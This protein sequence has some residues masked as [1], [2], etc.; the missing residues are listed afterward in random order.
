[1][2]INK[3]FILGSLLAVLLAAAGLFATHYFQSGRIGQAMLF[4]ADQ[5]RAAGTPD[6]EAK[7]L[8][9]YLEFRPD[10]AANLAR[11]AKLQDR[12][13]ISGKGLTAALFLYEKLLRLEP[14]DLDAR[15]AAA[16]LCLRLGRSADAVEHLQPLLKADPKDTKLHERLGRCMAAAGKPEE[17][18]KALQKAVELDPANVPA[19]QALIALALEERDNPER[20]KNARALADEMVARNPRSADA[21]LTMARLKRSQ[22][23][24]ADV[25][26]EVEAAQQ[27]DPENAEALVFA[28][29]AAQRAGKAD[30]A[31]ACYAA[32]CD[33]YASD[34]RGYRAMAWLA[35]SRQKPAEARAWLERGLARLPGE[36][37]L[38][39]PYAETLI[40]D[41]SAAAELAAVRDKLAADL[42][43][44]TA[45]DA[46]EYIDVRLA[47]RARK[48]ADAAERLL[49][50]RARALDRPGFAVQVEKML[51]DCYVQT[52]D[53]DAALACL[54]RAL[55][56]DDA[57]PD[58]R[59]RTA[60]I[61]A[62]IGKT[63]EAIAE[64]RPLAAAPNAPADAKL[65]LARMLLSRRQTAGLNKDELA[66]V[67]G[68]IDAAAADPK[69]AA[70]VA[71]MR[72][73]WHA[74]QHQFAQ[75]REVVS[76]ALSAAP[77]DVRLWSA[78]TDLTEEMDGYRGAL[79]VCETA[80]AKCGPSV[81]LALRRVGLQMALAGQ[82]LEVLAGRARAEA[83]KFQGADRARCLQG[84]GELFLRHKVTS[85][86]R[87]LFEEVMKGGIDS[88]VARGELFEIGLRENDELLQREVIART[89]ALGDAGRQQADTLRLRSLVAAAC[90]DKSRVAEA[91]AAV[92]AK[93]D[94]TPGSATLQQMAGRLAEARGDTGRA[95]EC[96]TRALDYNG[97]DEFSLERLTTIAAQTGRADGVERQLTTLA[98]RGTVPPEQ[99]EAAIDRVATRLSDTAVARLIGAL[100][101]D[102]SKS[103]RSRLWVANVLLRR[104]SPDKAIAMLRRAVMDAPTSA[105]AWVG[106]VK[107]FVAVGDKAQAE[108]ATEQMR[109]QVPAQHVSS[110]LSDCYE[111]Q[112]QFGKAAAVAEA[113]VRRKVRAML[114]SEND[115]DARAAL[116]AY[117]ATNPPAS[118]D[119]V[120]ARRTLAAVL[121]ADRKPE[122]VQ[123]AMQLLAA[124]L[125]EPNPT[126]DDR[127]CQAILL[128]SQRG[129]DGVK[130]GLAQWE[131]VLKSPRATGRDRFEYA[132]ALTAAGQWARAAAELD[133]VIK[134]DPQDAAAV[135]FAV[136]EWLLRGGR[137]RAA[138]YVEAAAGVT[139][140]DA[141]LTRAVANFYSLG[142]E[143]D[144]ALSVCT[145]QLN[146]AKT[147]AQLDDAAAVFAEQA[148]VAAGAWPG[149][150]NKFARQALEVYARYPQLPSARP[151][152]VAFLYSL[153]GA[154]AEGLAFLDKSKANLGAAQLAA[155]G[156][157]VLAA[158]SATAADFG[159]VQG[160]IARALQGT[161]ANEAALS[162]A[163]WHGLRGDFDG[164]EQVY[165]KV[166]RIDPKNVIAMNNLAWLL[167]HRG[168]QLDEAKTTI[169]RAIGLA[170]T[171]PELVDTR[172]RVEIAAR[173]YAAAVR[174]LDASMVE[175]QS[176][177]RLFHLALAH[178]KSGGRELA[179][180][181]F[182]RAQLFG[183][184]K[185]LLHPLEVGDYE[186]LS[187]LV[188]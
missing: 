174:D 23:P 29:D 178:S 62:R 171:H 35:S 124:N 93:I 107:G 162:L 118:E 167:A 182:R 158:G 135:G 91:E 61:Y 112:R 17:S 6:A 98:A 87:G 97:R 131:E 40:D 136:N 99:L 100:V 151:G 39:V 144:K 92:K 43:S 9:R 30:A 104:N 38:L 179:A 132:R 3:K 7:Y 84:L 102:D 45:G 121:G 150:K 8:A 94:E 66:E 168:R 50:L 165:R 88:A 155:D 161:Q 58:L 55:Q 54:N 53:R 169:D 36:V 126:L 83:D 116:E 33:L 68:L 148:R 4:Q 140:W 47:M 138:A 69:A 65:A 18:R 49:K 74:V 181:A 139:L 14:G 34:P 64:Y 11:Y 73:R 86:A 76:R 134:A 106:L 32:L 79:Q 31:A 63:D 187:R 143:L 75:G 5:A 147:L 130:A 77:A 52:G 37:D 176:A 70:E 81:E 175:S 72:S 85:V 48:W 20:A 173:D 129:T 119:L 159:V 28:A 26:A 137:D 114:L 109:T 163:E 12:K 133:A 89:A 180:V 149:A 44:R 153:A 117:L 22:K 170:G 15:R 156:V 10:D 110:A 115:K 1:M 46:A 141:A 71:L 164:A 13:A 120:W 111:A 2:A 42:S 128:C 80:R 95:T 19:H 78:L 96:Y 157:A 60:E 188:Q 21:Q 103:V 185:R 122:S 166:L 146:R 27:D 172:A 186:E 101:P 51:A 24:D 154:P 41:D 177:S 127:R 82:D 183:L 113:T 160:W 123:R 125:A 90:R 105:E 16:D 59:A 142:G 67:K 25:S 145:Q 56:L 108:R 152:R 184:S 57:S